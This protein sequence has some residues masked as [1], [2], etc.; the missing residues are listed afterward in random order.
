[1]M[2]KNTL[3]KFVRTKRV[4]KVIFIIFNFLSSIK[5]FFAQP[6]AIYRKN[7]FLFEKKYAL[8][9]GGPTPLFQTKNKK[10]PIY[11][12]LLRLDNC[13][14]NET[15]F[16]SSLKE[17]DLVKFDNKNS[18]KQIISDA[19]DLSKITDS[20]YDI[21]VNSHVI[22]HIANPIKALLEWRRVIK[23][24][25][26]LLMVVPH[27]DGTYDI[28]RPVTKL[29]HIIKDYNDNMTED[30]TTHFQEVLEL[31][32]LKLDTTVRDYD[33]HRERTHD[34]INRRIVHH[35]VFDTLLVARI[36]DYVGFK[37][38]DIQQ[39]KPYNIIILAQKHEQKTVKN[40]SFLDINSILYKESIFPTDRP[41]MQKI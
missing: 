18:G 8:E 26:F 39:V 25:G 29:D 30:D 19:S 41:M 17:G 36:I 6:L 40:D 7:K 10:I 9:I 35:H 15:N 37:I 3:R 2:M 33:D 13:N 28:K 16:W 11:A 34:N 32:D 22:E 5:L 14:F 1:M 4:Q 21:L 12:D 31:H 24:N 20:T 38:I 23:D 27:K